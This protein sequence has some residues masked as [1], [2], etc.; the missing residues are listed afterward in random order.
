MLSLHNIDSK[1]QTEIGSWTVHCI[2]CYPCC[3]LNR[4]GII[5]DNERWRSH[6]LYGNYLCK[7]IKKTYCP[8]VPTPLSKYLCGSTPAFP[9]FPHEVIQLEKTI[10]KNTENKLKSLGLECAYVPRPGTTLTL[11][12]DW[13][14]EEWLYLHSGCMGQCFT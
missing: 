14:K 7:M 1:W 13:E 2:H 10:Y 6:L 11:Y 3:S 4:W 9:G 5:L 12:G 8:Y